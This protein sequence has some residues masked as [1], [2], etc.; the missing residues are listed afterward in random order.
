[1]SDANGSARILIVDDTPQNIQ[2]LGT[3]LRTEGYE[4]NVA[5]NGVEALSIADAALPDLILLDIMMP[6]M[7][8]YETC[9]RLKASDRTRDIPVIFLTAKTEMDDILKGF[10]LGAVDYITKPFNQQEL[11]VRVRTHVELQSLRQQAERRAEQAIAERDRNLRWALLGKAT[12][13]FVGRYEEDVQ[14][15][16][17]LAEFL[18]RGLDDS[19]PNRARAVSM[20]RLAEAHLRQLV[21][22]S[23]MTQEEMKLAREDVGLA[24]F[25]DRFV[26]VRYMRESGSSRDVKV[27]ADVRYGGSV[28]IDPHRVGSAL[29]KIVDY[30]VGLCRQHEPRT[31]PAIDLV[32]HEDADWVYIGVQSPDTGIP[33]ERQQT[34]FDE[35]HHDDRD[36]PE[37]ALG[38]YYAKRVVD[39]HGGAI[40]YRFRGGKSVFAMRLPK[41]A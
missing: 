22:I 31:T 10:E 15:I 25:I 28:R 17:S 11:L 27:S 12:P 26:R 40:V 9:R 19:D 41:R 7:D 29:E 21:E 32:T 6:E 2:V 18:T 8:G 13:V 3:T 39:E 4:L 33:P 14:R 30:A 23:D 5:E 20:E 35:A 37:K 1:M 38:L 36:D 34:L 24:Q 16:R